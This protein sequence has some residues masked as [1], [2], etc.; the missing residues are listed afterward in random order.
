MDQ[1]KIVTRVG[2]VTHLLKL[3]SEFSQMRN[4]LNVSWLE[5]RSTGESSH[6]L[7][8]NIQDIGLVK[9][10]WDHRNGSASTWE[11]D[12]ERRSNY[13]KIF[14]V[15]AI[16]GMKSCVGGTSRADVISAMFSAEQFCLGANLRADLFSANISA[17]PAVMFLSCF[18]RRSFEVRELL[19]VIHIKGVA[20]RLHCQGLGL[21]SLSFMLNPLWF[22]WFSV[23]KSEDM[24]PRLKDA[25][26]K[27]D[28]RTGSYD[29]LPW[30]ENFRR[31]IKDLEQLVQFSR[32]LKEAS[33]H[34]YAIKFIDEVNP[35]WSD[36][37]D[38][39]K[40]FLWQ[41][42]ATEEYLDDDCLDELRDETMDEQS[43]G[44]LWEDFEQWGYEKQNPKENLSPI[45]SKVNLP[46][47]ECDDTNN[48]PLFCQVNSHVNQYEDPFWEASCQ[49]QLDEPTH[50]MEYLKDL[51]PKMPNPYTH[52]AKKQNTN[53]SNKW[54]ATLPGGSHKGKSRHRMNLRTA[55]GEHEFLH[56][57]PHPH[58]DRQ[59]LTKE[60]EAIKSHHI[61]IGWTLDWDVLQ[62]IQA[63]GHILRYFER[64]PREPE[65]ELSGM[66]WKTA[67][68][69]RESVYRELTLEFITTYS[70]DE[71]RGRESVRQSCIQYRLG[72]R[73]F[74][75]SLA[76]FAVSLGLYTAGMVGTDYF[77]YYI[78]QCALA[79]PEDLDF[80][81]LWSQLGHGPYR[82]S[83]TKSGGLVDPEHR[84][85]HRMIA[86][87]LNQ[88]KSS[89]DKIGD[90]ELWL[91]H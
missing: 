37:D 9:V 72:G 18:V 20:L 91:L 16:S 21:C 32:Q 25:L 2:W 86:Y 49:K 5:K 4:T 59:E 6:D 70:F 57:G 27:I 3:P 48:E 39:N 44:E 31:V 14:H 73:W 61:E 15:Q 79:P 35:P 17:K 10:Q 13:T 85:I 51:V 28:E 19:S 66:A 41:D 83:N 81:D 82:R 88:R 8:D 46:I 74:R 30:E 68:D 67:L 22:M 63:A 50:I 23:R 43:D 40:E 78:G 7:F 60:L 69:L 71:E 56:F 76:Q 53:Q 64:G 38:S 58:H 34:D 36:Y 12:A 89:Q 42:N 54:Y 65:S 90:F 33:T 26:R 84:V 45:Q 77:E 47:S 24:D 1:F 52:S 80:C 11:P 29:H 75:Q 87:T 62:G 55:S